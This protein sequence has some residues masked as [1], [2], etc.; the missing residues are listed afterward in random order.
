MSDIESEEGED[1]GPNLGVCISIGA[2]D[3]L[4]SD[5]CRR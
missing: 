5:L 1:Q 2:S 3:S 4:Y